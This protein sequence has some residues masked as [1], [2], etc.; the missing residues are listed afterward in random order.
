MVHKERP[1]N[2]GDIVELGIEGISHQGWG[3]GRH[4]GF[5]VFVPGALPE[6]KVKAKIKQVKKNYAIADL[7]QVR[8]ESSHRIKDACSVYAA[9][10]GCHMQHAQYEHQLDLKRKIVADALS[11]I[12]KLEN[13]KVKPV[14]GMTEP[15]KY[16]NRIQLHV[17]TNERQIKIG[18]FKPGTHELVSFDACRLVPDIF[19]DIRN[20]LTGEL[21]KYIDS[22]DINL[23]KNIKHMV[24]K[25]SSYTEEITIVF[26]TSKKDFKLINRLG[27]ALINKFNNVV[28]VVQNIQE[29]TSGALFGPKWQLILGKDRV[30]DKIG[31]VIFSISPGS[32]VQVN[33]EQTE[34]LYQQVL[35]YAGLTGTETVVDL[36]CGIGTISLLLA[37]KAR[38]VIGIEEF[39][40]AVSDAQNNALINNIKN[41]EFIAGKAEIIF[42]QMDVSGTKPD[43]IVVDPPRSGCAPVVLEAIVNVKPQKL[44]YVSC[45][46]ATL[47]R[48]LRILS[49]KGYKVLE[50]QPVDMFPQTAGIES[51]A[52]LI[53]VGLS[54]P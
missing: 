32:F 30:E 14:L 50:I 12:G 39:K 11:K 45:D 19:N 29:R 36:Y 13:L 6:E 17:I 25:I 1:L 51:V 4:E 33:P 48:D 54:S 49:E 3:I 46:P 37:G 26:V 18:F 35:D 27:Q 16:R 53:P 38:R 42:P 10:G 5:T 20:Y 31:D 43:I 44:I 8:T 21:N 34:I 40:D 2:L 7:V 24:L 52:V 22:E 9:C 41:A 28:S 15:W 23:I 47:A